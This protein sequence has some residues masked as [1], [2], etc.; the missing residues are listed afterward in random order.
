MNKDQPMSSKSSRIVRWIGTIFSL[1]LLIF[2]IQR[3]GWD[4][5]FS[6]FQSLS[7]G[8]FILGLILIMLSRLAV[9]GRWHLLL[10]R[11]ENISL[12]QTIKVTFAGLFATNFL[13]T[14]VG[15]DLVRFAGA[16]R[17]GINGTAAAASLVVDRLIGMFGMISAL[18]F[19]ASPLL[20]WMNQDRLSQTEF[21]FGVSFSWIAGLRQKAVETIQKLKDALRIWSDHPRAL[22]CSFCFTVI[23]M[24]CTFGTIKILFS[25]LGEILPLPLI[26]GLWSFVYFVTLLPVSF[27]GYGV[28]EI[29]IAFIYSEVGGVSLESGLTVSVIFRTLMI[30]ASL[31]GAMFVPGILVRENELVEPES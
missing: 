25:D 22:I 13:P 4:E 24:L 1:I 15:G 6:A 8:N 29:S 3:Q 23:H 14:T 16:V 2:L 28:Q 31:P 5:I 27:N 18:P 7:W 26:G 11:I 10:K 20:R 30:L 19:G 9:I 17:L 12:S 21:L